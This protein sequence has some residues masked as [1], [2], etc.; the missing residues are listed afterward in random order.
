MSNKV[1]LVMMCGACC[2]IGWLLGQGSITFFSDEK[3]LHDMPKY[4]MIAVSKR[5]YVLNTE[6]GVVWKELSGECLVQLRRVNYIPE[7]A[8]I[9]ENAEGEPFKFLD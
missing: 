3:S 6:T 2:F 1:L 4:S 5:C 9:G 7:M 8:F